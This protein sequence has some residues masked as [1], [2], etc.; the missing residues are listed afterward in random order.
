M[1]EGIV[2]VF[3][4][5]TYGVGFAAGALSTLSPCALPLLPVLAASAL[6]AHRFGNLALATGLGVSFTAIGLFVATVGSTI[7][8]TGDTFRVFAAVLMVVFGLLMAFGTMQHLFARALSPVGNMAQRLLAG[9]RG[10]GLVGQ[11]AIGMLLGIVWSPCVG[12]TL[13]AASTLASQGQDLMH[14]AALMAVFGMGAAVPLLALGAMS[15]ATIGKL[16]GGLGRFG[17]IGRGALGGLFVAVGALI[18]SGTDK[19]LQ[20]MLLSHSPDWL[21]QLTTSL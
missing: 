19:A 15:R 14:I 8:L 10:D 5:A 9:I 21:V 12:P 20:A 18:L 2:I 3:G 13:G 6:S 4:P 11:F 16:R 17:R 1:G 7:G